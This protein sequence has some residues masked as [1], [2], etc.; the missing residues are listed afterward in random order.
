MNV[1]RRDTLLSGWGRTSPSRGTVAE[2][3]RDDVTTL[4]AL[5]RLDVSGRG[6]IP[7]GL[8]RSY[9]DPAQNGGG[10][11]LRLDPGVEPIDVDTL[12]GTAT[13]DSGVD[14]DTLLRRIVPLGWFVPVTPGTRFVTVGGAI[15]SDIHGKNHHT[16]GSFGRHLL[17]M[18]MLLA[19]GSETHVTP[20]SDPALWRAT[21]GGMGLTGI[22]LEATFRLIPI[23]TSSCLVDTE[24]V[25]NLDVL[26]ATMEEG[27]DRYRYS[28]AWIDLL[29]TGSSL[30]RSVLT[31][32]DHATMADFDEHRRRSSKDPLHF[33]PPTLPGV[34]QHVP[35]VLPRPAVR[36]FNEVWYRKAPRRHRGVEGITGFFHPLDMVGDWNRLYGR[37]G[38]LQYQFVVPFEAV[39]T[40]RAVITRVSDAGHASFLAVLKRLGERSGGHLS[41]PMP[42]WTLTLDLPAGLHGLG[43]LL[44]DLDSLVIAAGGRHYL[45]KDAHTTPEVIRAGYPDLDEWS[46]VRARVD[47]NRRW[48]SDQARRLGLL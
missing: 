4:G 30:G 5:G 20:D 31:R 45:A 41:F 17:S 24:R 11:V 22:V 28:V 8:G 3:G 46:N 27:D 18:T 35:N 7:R 15:A 1:R 48:R 47:P 12:E 25:P 36:A 26:V 13:V 33:D 40:L 2:L 9:G 37:N 10:T 21:I 44:A 19:D 39:D 32:A 29:A 42:G 43:P 6:L 38:F 23:E 16:D 34:P 14:F